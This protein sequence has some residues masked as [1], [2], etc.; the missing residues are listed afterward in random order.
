MTVIRRKTG[1]VIDVPDEKKVGRQGRT[2][3]QLRMSPT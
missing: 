1:I 2:E 3:V